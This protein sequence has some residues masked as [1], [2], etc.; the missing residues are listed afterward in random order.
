MHLRL[1]PQRWS[2]VAKHRIRWLDAELRPQD[3][4]RLAV[5]MAE[6]TASS[7]STHAWVLDAV[8]QGSISGRFVERV[9]REIVT[10]D[11]DGIETRA[12]V[13]TYVHTAFRL[14]VER[15]AI[16]L[17]LPARSVSL[18]LSSLSNLLDQ[19]IAITPFSFNPLLWA[20][21]VERNHP[22]TVV[23]SVELSGIAF[24]GGATGHLRLSGVAD[25]RVAASQ[26]VGMRTH[27]VRKVG[28][29]CVLGDFVLGSGGGAVVGD[30]RS[31]LIEALRLAL[32]SPREQ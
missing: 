9:P 19:S 5:G 30:S 11:A 22:S 25:V 13:P 2:I 4:R 28:G 15:P 27:S 17:H 10:V 14:T 12:S 1:T 24:R 26:I 31:P 7:D 3:L 23:S 21:A 6:T 32:V 8:R 16:E 20:E 18:I 29:R